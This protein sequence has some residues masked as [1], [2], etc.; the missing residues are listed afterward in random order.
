[1]RSHTFASLP[2]RGD[3]LAVS[4]DGLDLS[5]SMVG[6]GDVLIDL[7]GTGTPTVTGAGE[8]IKS[9]V[10]NQL[11][12]SLSGLGEHDVT[13]LF[14]ARVTSVAFSADTGLSSTDFVTNA[15]PQTISGTLSGPLGAGDV[16]RVSLD[17]GATWLTAT[18]AG[19]A[20]SFSLAGVTLTSRNTLIARVENATGTFFVHRCRRPMCWTPSRKPRQT[21]L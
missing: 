4:G 15:A 1:M 3:L 9:L 18:V 8:T 13:I 2:M 19:G 16:V 10:G 6:A 5:F 21:W 12:L 20:M 11:D 7:G 17:N 14:L